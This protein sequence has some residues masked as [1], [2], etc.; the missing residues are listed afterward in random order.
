MIELIISIML[1]LFHLNVSGPLIKQSYA[2]P[3]TEE[4]RTYLVFAVKTRNCLC[5]RNSWCQPFFAAYFYTDRCCIVVVEAFIAAVK[6]YHI[7]IISQNH[8][9]VTGY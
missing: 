9:T 2:F 6:F 1:S 5:Y 3:S 4:Q 7:V 8:S